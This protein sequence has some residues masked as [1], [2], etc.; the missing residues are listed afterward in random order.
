VRVRQIAS[1]SLS[2]DARPMRRTRRQTPATEPPTAPVAVELVIAPAALAA[3]L[4]LA[5]GDRRRLRFERDGSVTIL[6]RPR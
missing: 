6:N 3:A 2:A 1:V 4:K 5:G